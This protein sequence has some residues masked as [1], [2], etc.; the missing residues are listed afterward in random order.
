MNRARGLAILAALAVPAAWFAATV[1]PG[2]QPAQAI[3]DPQPAPVPALA[4][5]TSE[6]E[7]RLVASILD[8][9]RNRPQAALAELDRILAENPEFRLA[10]LVRG[11]I[12]M[13][14]AGPITTFGYA[15]SDGE[16]LEDLRAEARARLARL[17]AELPATRLPGYLLQLDANQRHVLVVDTARST[18]YVFEHRDGEL[19]YVRDF[20]TSVGRNGIDKRIQGD[21]RTPLGVYHVT[22]H[23]PG[24][25]LIDFYGPGA[26]PINYPNEWDRRHGRTGHGIWL[27]GVPGDTFARAPLSSDGCLVL[28]NADFT[29]LAP[30]IQAGVT[31]VLISARVQWVDAATRDARRAAL[32]AAVEAWRRDWESRDAARLLEHYSAEFRAGRRDLAQ[33]SERKRGALA[34]SR[35]IRVSVRNLSLL[36][37][38]GHDH[39]VVATF[40]QEFTSDRARNEMR[41]RQYWQLEDGRWRIVFEGP[42]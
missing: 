2:I 35:S 28:A 3:I 14:R 27:H 18:L 8:V 20:Y 24:E 7:Q 36:A 1:V 22:S 12:L 6:V 21:R 4:R 41:K 38:P 26:F 10:H 37:Y 19:R 31:P 39:L 17:A 13:A 29:A 33:W 11:D 25:K 40:D 16:R 34:A 32:A 15:A 30:F 23:I 5:N 42:A 9:A